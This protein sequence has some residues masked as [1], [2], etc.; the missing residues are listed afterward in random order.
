MAVARPYSG[1][2]PICYVLPVIWDVNVSIEKHVSRAR[3]LVLF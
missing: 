2:V 1:G 3:V